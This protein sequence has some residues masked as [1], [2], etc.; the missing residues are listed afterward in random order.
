M[1]RSSSQHRP[2][3]VVLAVIDQQL[4]D[5]AAHAAG[6]LGR[7]ASCSITMDVAGELRRSASSDAAAAACDDAEVE[8]GD[9]PCL[10][11]MADARVVVVD[12][13]RAER[14]W[15]GWTAA[16]TAAGFRSAGA[17][18]GHSRSGTPVAVNVYR[19]HAGPWQADELVR[20]DLYAQQVARVLDLCLHIGSLQH[21]HRVLREA[22]A[23]Q[24]A[25]DQAVG[26]VMATRGCDAATALAELR[27][28][29]GG[30]N[31]TL[32]AAAAA[33]LDDLQP[34]RTV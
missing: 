26:A 4:D 31:G 32:S 28:A 19:R 8:T 9:G 14:R 7:A 27:S 12:D 1:D 30:R 2:H 6:A 17:F 15:P 20:A 34:P 13:V 23:A 29:A 24:A 18:P 5:F 25:I 21:Q 11:A 10:D 3:P 22:L 33:V 16:T